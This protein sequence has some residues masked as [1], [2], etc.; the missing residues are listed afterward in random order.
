MGTPK[1]GGNFEVSLSYQGRG[2]DLI[3]LE[4][5]LDRGLSMVDS[6]V[7]NRSVVG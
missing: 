5:H 7:T 1:P 6:A 2:F 3:D 4:E